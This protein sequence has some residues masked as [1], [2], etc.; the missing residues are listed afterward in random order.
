MKK[1]YPELQEYIPDDNKNNNKDDN[2][3]DIISNN[4][5]EKNNKVEEYDNNNNNEIYEMEKNINKKKKFKY[6]IISENSEDIN[7]IYPI[8]INNNNYDENVIDLV[9]H[10]E[11]VLNREGSILY[12]PKQNSIFDVN[13]MR[14]IRMQKLLSTKYYPI[15]RRNINFIY[16]FPFILKTK[17]NP[18]LSSIPTVDDLIASNISIGMAIDGFSELFL[19]WDDLLKRGLKIHHLKRENGWFDIRILVGYFKATWV[20]LK[21]IG[22]SVDNIIELKLSPIDCISLE[23][24][25]DVLINELGMNKYIMMELNFSYNDWNDIFGFNGYHFS[26]LSLNED[27]INWLSHNRRWPN[28]SKNIQN[29]IYYSRKP[30]INNNYNKNYYYNKNNNNNNNIHLNSDRHKYNYIDNN[31]KI[32]AI[33]GPLEI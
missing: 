24:N 21:S 14:D 29:N 13:L 9:E 12:T 15:K 17:F 6:V 20:Q 4:C 26:K 33:N 1:L 28:I 11:D 23:I 3:N 5:T 19:S 25:I 16:L 32:T 8:S 31:I 30:N 10:P 22:F 2:N 7:N 27:D 18:Y